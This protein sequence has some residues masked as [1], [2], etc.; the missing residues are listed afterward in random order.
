LGFGLLGSILI[1]A[2]EECGFWVLPAVGLYTA[3]GTGIGVGVDALIVRP[4]PIFRRRTTPAA[5]VSVVPLL[6]GPRKGA[7]ITVAF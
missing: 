3:M 5:R 7:V 2:V 4:T 6:I 1:C